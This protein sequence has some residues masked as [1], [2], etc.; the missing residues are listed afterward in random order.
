MNHKS[1]NI[2]QQ[3]YERLSN[4][5]N[6]INL[7]YC[8]LC[9]NPVTHP[10]YCLNCNDCFCLECIN[11]SIESSLYC[12]TCR[13]DLFLKSSINDNPPSNL[14]LVEEED[15]SND[16][17]IQCKFCYKSIELASFISHFNNH[18]QHC[19]KE[20]KQCFYCSCITDLKKCV[21]KKYLCMECLQLQKNKDCYK[22]CYVYSTGNNSTDSSETCYYT[23]KY[24]LGK[25]FE[26]KVLFTKVYWIRTGMAISKDILHLA[27]D[28]NSPQYDILYQLEDLSQIYYQKS[29]RTYNRNNISENRQLSPGDY[30]TVRMQSNG[31]VEFLLNDVATQ[32]IPAIDFLNDNANIFLLKYYSKSVI[33]FKLQFLEE[34]NANIN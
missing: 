17:L 7:I 28:D 3:N 18:F 20:D 29:W 31:E 21:C 22:T 19:F 25:L 26:F 6:Q 5:K 23:S 16:Q 27:A 32:T 10:C 9:R 4:N 12:P 30:I 24:P 33:I 8:Y 1:N 34:Y 11:Y 2:E 15:I 14:L 13:K